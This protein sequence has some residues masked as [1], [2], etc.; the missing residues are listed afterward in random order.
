MEYY[1][2]TREDGERQTVKAHLEG[3]S[4]LAEGFSVDFLKPL[5]KKAAFDHDLG[6]YALKYQWR[7]DDDNIKFSHAAC[8]A[9]EYK[10]FADKNDCFASLF[11]PLM[12][13]CIAGHHTGLMDGGT[14]ADNSDSPT[15]SGT[16]KR[17]NEY[18]GDSDYS[19]YAT[20]I[21]FA[22]LTQEEIT[23]PYNELCSAKDPTELIERYA[24]FTK[25]VFSCLTD[26]DFLDTEI[27]CNKNVERGMSG[28]FEKALDK[29]NRE[30][31]DMPSDNPLRQARSRIQQ[32]A[33]DNSVN[34][35]HISILDMPTGSGKTL[36]SLKLA[37]ESGKKRIIYVIPYTSIIEQ[38]A[39]KFEKMFGDVLPVLQHHS[40]YSYDGNTEE[41]KKTVEK[42][43]RTCENW[44]AP[45]IITTSV[46]FF[47]SIYHYKGSALRKLHNLRDSVIVFDEIH[48]IPTELL[49]PCLKA[50]GYI[51]KYLNSEALFL[52]ATMPDYSK[53]F[54]KFLPDVNYNKLVTDRT[55]FKYFKKCEYKDMGK[56]TLETIAENASRCKNALIV[57]NTKKTAAELY[58][59]VQGEK[60]HLSA[61]MTPAHRSRVIEVVRNK[62]ENGEPITV[63]STSLVEA[64]VDLDFNT[65]FRQLSGLDSILQAGGRC[66]REGKDAKGYVYVF[67]ID[68]T[69]RK[70]SDLAM[71][72]N[73]TKGLLEKYQ[74]ITSY[75]CIKEYYDG[76]FDFNQ[77]R[78]A[79]NSIAK[80]NE[81]SNS[82]DRQGL[83]SPYS[84]PFRSYA[85]QFEYISA[86]TISIVIDDPNDQTCHELVE[87]LR[88]GDMSVRRALQKY[89]VSV[90]MNVFKDLYSQGVLNDHG[91]GIF[92]L[93]NQSYYNNETGL[94]TQ[95]AMQDYFI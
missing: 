84:I 18:T 72:I 67:D 58:N 44:D 90:Y 52:S 70:G 38:T 27:F 19:A 51:T 45:L 77:S 56:T 47:Q 1:A 17:G 55:N 49:R 41:E 42:L 73:K 66:N 16:L 75:D 80:Y 50:V 86:D 74:D 5:A 37:L 15:L 14:D 65:V 28:D 9:L 22:T 25:F 7:L 48:L 6:K 85:M 30:L 83:M 87:T 71:R 60:Y 23:P 88:N 32:Q 43:K 89:S 33:F 3:V 12:E 76:I 82:F 4:K 13:Y 64:G 91:T 31:S 8:G 54:D 63:V 69:Y 94:N 57:V 26:A 92:I 79:E 59:L 68:E 39:N 81:Q 36:C 11:A 78:I 21:E 34:K 40:N 62:L 20:E 53:L 35:S 61:N 29:L 10:K 93:E 24:F 46:Q 95:A 2:H